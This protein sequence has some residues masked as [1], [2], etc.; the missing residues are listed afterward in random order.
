MALFRGI[1]FTYKLSKDIDR[2]L[3]HETGIVYSQH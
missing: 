3:K 2:L 1:C